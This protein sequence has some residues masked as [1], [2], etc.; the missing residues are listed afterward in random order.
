MNL[1][2]IIVLHGAPKDS[3]TSTETYLVTP[4]EETVAEWINQHKCYG[5]WFPGPD[6]EEENTRC[7]DGPEYKEIP[8]REWV[9]KH[10]GDLDDEEGWADAYY[11]VTKWGWEKIDGATPEDLETLIDLGIAVRHTES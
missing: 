5:H 1:Y 11:G 4:D 2:R 10:K 7:D 3:H 8:F 6:E 9:M